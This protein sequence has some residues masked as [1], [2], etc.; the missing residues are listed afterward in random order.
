MVSMCNFQ[1]LLRIS[2]AYLVVLISNSASCTDSVKQ[3][4]PNT[5]NTDS[6]ESRD[7]GVDEK[8]HAH[9][10]THTDY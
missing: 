8:L 7:E 5:N 10:H 2:E 4:L 6:D 9:T 3:A 1:N